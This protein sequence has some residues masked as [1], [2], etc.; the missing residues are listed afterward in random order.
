M[1]DKFTILTLA[2]IKLLKDVASRWDELSGN[3][4]ATECM[5]DHCHVEL[6]ELL[7]ITDLLE[8]AVRDGIRVPDV[9]TFIVDGEEFP[10]DYCCRVPREGEGEHTG[11]EYGSKGRKFVFKLCDDEESVR[12]AQAPMCFVKNPCDGVNGYPV[13]NGELRG[14]GRVVRVMLE[15]A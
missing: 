15:D 4:E 13:W 10:L 12:W 9:G 1:P 6:G 2:D 5:T 3:P 7:R 8:L 11:W 14:G